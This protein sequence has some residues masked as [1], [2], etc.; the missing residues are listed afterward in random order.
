MLYMGTRNQ[1]LFPAAKKHA[2]LLICRS[3]ALLL[4]CSAALL[5][6][7]TPGAQEEAPRQVQTD[8]KIGLVH[9]RSEGL[10]S[11]GKGSIAWVDGTARCMESHIQA[12]QL[13]SS[14]GVLKRCSM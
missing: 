8:T 5:L 10:G 7:S 6:C 2:T 11:T 4:C 1:K 12:E 14:F 13:V 9:A 3:A